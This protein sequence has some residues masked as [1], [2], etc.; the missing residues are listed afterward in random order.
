V[1]ETPVGECFNNLLVAWA[2]LERAYAWVKKPSTG[3]LALS[4]A[5]RPTQVVLWIGAGRGLRGGPMRNGAGPTIGSVVKFEQNWWSWWATLQ[6]PWRVRDR[7]HPER[8]SREEYGGKT[9]EDWETL[10][11]PGVNGMLSVVAALYWWGVKLVKVVDSEEKR[12]WVEAVRDVKWMIAGLTA[13]E[14]GATT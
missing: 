5:S 2:E 12:T 11:V 1:T 8:F 6:P 9:Q 14:T 3:R 4:A 13:V 7:G 10:R